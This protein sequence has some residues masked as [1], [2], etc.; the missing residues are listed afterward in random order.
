MLKIQKCLSLKREFPKEISLRAFFTP[1]ACARNKLI[2]RAPIVIP[3]LMKMKSIF[4]ITPHLV[5]SFTPPLERAAGIPMIKARAPKNVAAFFRVHK[6]KSE[7]HNT[8]NI[9]SRH[10]RENHRKDLEHEA[11]IGLKFSRNNPRRSKK[12]RKNDNPGQ[13]SN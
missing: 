6:E 3:K 12:C 7:E 13:D 4:I 2:K 9:T 10:F 11:G 1:H 5:K 8:K